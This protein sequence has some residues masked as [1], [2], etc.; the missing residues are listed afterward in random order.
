MNTPLS[1]FQTLLPTSNITPQ[2]LY[3]QALGQGF[4]DDPAQLLGVTA[5]NN[6]FNQL[7]AGEA[8]Q[9]VYL[10]GQVGRGKT[11]LMNAM[12]LSLEANGIASRRQHFHHFMRWLH[13]ELFQMMGTENPLQQLAAQLADEIQVLCFDEVFIND[14]GDAVLLAPLFTALFD[15]DVVL[16]ATSNQAPLSLYDQGHNRERILPAL[17]NLASKLEIVHLDGQQDHRLHGTANSPK[18]WIFSH[19]NKLV[20]S[21]EQLLNSLTVDSLK[22]SPLT[23]LFTELAGQVPQPT[24]IPLNNRWLE[25]LGQDKDAGVIYCCF[26]QLCGGNYT[27]ADYIDLCQTYPHILLANVP[28]LGAQAEEQQIA[29]GTEDAASQ[30]HAGDRQLMAISKLDNSVRRFIALV[31]ECYEQ[32]VPL[33][34]EAAVPLAELYTQGALLFPFQ[35]TYSRLQEMQKSGFGKQLF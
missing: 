1:N 10:W 5:L 21:S 22:N 6:C 12:H 13:K 27:A 23:K 20:A 3:Q 18:Y 17:E 26:D 7:L 32:G 34:I 31:D 19:I 14:I 11:W 24:S 16:I 25:V 9:G 28:Q 35:R 4:V 2:Q 15:L 8:T 29:R 30:V 33:Y